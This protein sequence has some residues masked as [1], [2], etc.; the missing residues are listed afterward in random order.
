MPWLPLNA[1]TYGA[2]IDSMFFLITWITGITFVLVQVTLLVFLF[3]YRD[4]GTR[5]AYY[6]HGSASLEVVWTVIPSI[7]L[8]VLAF[9]SKA[10][11]DE[12]KV[13]TPPG[14]IRVEVIGKQFNWE[15]VYPGPDREFGTGDDLTI[16]NQLHVPVD[17][18]V[19]VSL[20]SIDVIHSFFVPQLR[21]KQDAVPGRTISVWFEATREGVY[22]IPCAELCGFGH[23]GMKGLLTVHNQ[24]DYDAWIEQNWPAPA[25]ETTA[26]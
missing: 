23:S 10:K 24:T 6:T 8:V 3:L 5:R 19:V 26:S 22:E 21:I 15:V 18:V 14:D 11:W 17:K 25:V 4:R 7:I 12:I 9:L 20:K 2:D 1:S 16:D 13:D